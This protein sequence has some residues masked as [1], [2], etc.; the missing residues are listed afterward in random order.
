M[1]TYL[2]RSTLAELFNENGYFVGVFPHFI[3]LKMASFVR[4]FKR[5]ILTAAL[6]V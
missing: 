4:A 1:T 2:L 5:L 3:Y 6:W